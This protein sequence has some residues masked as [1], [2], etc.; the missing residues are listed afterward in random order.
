MHS[1]EQF[2]I[3]NTRQLIVHASHYVIEEISITLY[4]SHL[5]DRYHAVLYHNFDVAGALPAFFGAR[6]NLRNSR[7]FVLG[8]ARSD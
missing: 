6:T 8:E 1:I 3:H 4:L 2:D 7:R 5:E